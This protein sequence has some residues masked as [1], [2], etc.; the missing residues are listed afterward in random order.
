[1]TSRPPA[2]PSDKVSSRLE[3][4]IRRNVAAG[5]FVLFGLLGGATLWSATA[6]ISGAVIARGVVAVE[7]SAKKVQHPE[8]GVVA[9]LAVRN[10]DEVEA[11]QLLLRL[12]DTLARANL[13]I[14]VKSLD[15]L[16]ALQARLEAE[17]DGAAAIAPGAELARRVAEDPEAAAALAGQVT[18][19]ES[20]R[21]A[22]ETARIQLGEQIA[23]LESAIE[24]LTAQQAARERE[25]ALIDEELRGV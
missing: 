18:V 8:G 24:G 9:A 11:G 19:F 2:M 10:G 7:S 15:Q 17:R 14:I 16:L 3:A 4:S 5:F 13:A 6:E 25:L 20:R 21:A 22:R 1:E 23:Q 12:D